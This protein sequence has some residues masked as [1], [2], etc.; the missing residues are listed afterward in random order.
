ME[1]TVH[2][3]KRGAPRALVVD[4]D[5][6]MRVMVG[7]VLT[8]FGLAVEEAEDGER[9]VQQRAEVLL[10][11]GGRVIQ[12][13]GVLQDITERRNAEEMIRELVSYDALTGLPNR[14]F[15]HDQFTRAIAIAKRL[16]RPLA[17]LQ[18]NIDRFKRIN[19][20]LGRSTGDT[21]L[22]EIARGLTSRHC[23]A[24]PL[25]QLRE[26]RSGVVTTISSSPSR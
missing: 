10:E 11:E 1:R 21:L 23:F 26:R 25:P 2:P 4:D 12:V 20:T 19:E 7:E 6:T 5:D 24:T 14:K 22:K 18:V 15:F 9:I 8:Q 13:H 17:V 16:G 3:L